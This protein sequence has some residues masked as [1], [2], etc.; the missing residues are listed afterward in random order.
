MAEICNKKQPKRST[1][2][3]NMWKGPAIKQFK[4]HRCYFKW[5]FTGLPVTSTANKLPNLK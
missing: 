5:S 1:L 3:F 4:R 2:F